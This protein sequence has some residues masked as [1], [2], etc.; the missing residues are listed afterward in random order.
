M[1]VKEPT[2]VRVRAAWI[3]ALAADAI[4]VGGLPIFA[5]GVLSPW[6]DVL[7]VIV[8]ALMVALLGWHW[9][10]IPTL[11]AESL[12][13]VDLIPSWTAAVLFVTRG[14]GMPIPAGAPV[15]PGIE[16]AKDVTPPR[17]TIAPPKDESHS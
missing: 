7:D 4:Q 8:A 3:V 17:A 14:S 13:L 16:G 10:F 12:P 15:L 5:E 6:N 2:P 1:Q 11:V 9:A